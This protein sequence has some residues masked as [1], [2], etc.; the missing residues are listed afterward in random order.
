MR[1]IPATPVQSATSERKA[2]GMNAIVR[3]FMERNEVPGLSVAVAK[4][5]RIVYARGFGFAESASKQLVTVESRFRIA[6]IT[7][8]ITAVTI[9]TLVEQRKLKLTDRVFG[10][11]GVLGT[12]HGTPPYE[13]Y[14]QQV[15]VE[16]LLAHT[17][18][19]WLNDAADPMFL[20]PEMEHA[21][22][23]SWTLDNQSLAHE[24]GTSYAY[25][26]FGY[27]LLGRIIEK[28]TGRA[29]AA[30]V[31]QRVLRPCGITAME[32]A[33]NTLVERQRDEVVYYGQEGDDPYE[34]PVRRMDSHGGWIA[35]AVDLVRFAIHVDDFPQ[36]PDIL[37]QDTIRTM[38]TGSSANPDYALGWAV[39][40]LGDWWHGGSLPGT[41]TILMRTAAGFCWA[42]LTNTRRPGL[43]AELDKVI[44]TAVAAMDLPA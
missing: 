43:G 35:S 29:Y 2:V 24:P 20:N 15:T 30:A 38:T 22:L 13:A 9:L 31:R 26:N 1:R 33:G 23:I 16:H 44:R 7:K 28:V 37:R 42:A 14:V 10:E 21:S 34:P 8:P 3:E 39:N 40:S 6:S 41:S 18:G 4:N 17:S 11:A 32:I 5:D 36:Q 19:G 12:T 25:S 27:C